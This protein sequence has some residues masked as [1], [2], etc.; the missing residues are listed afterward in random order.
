MAE[1]TGGSG[2]NS[3]LPSPRTVF[4]M[5]ATSVDLW[6][7]VGG[8]HRQRVVERTGAKGEGCRRAAGVKHRNVSCPQL[9]YLEVLE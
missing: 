1:S 6:Q 7:K 9:K 8:M 4:R 2:R 3:I 5:K